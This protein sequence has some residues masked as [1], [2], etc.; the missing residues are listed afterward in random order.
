MG[1]REA[2]KT[3]WQGFSEVPSIET[4]MLNKNAE[5]FDENDRKD[6][7]TS[8]PDLTGLRVVEIG[9]GIG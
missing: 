7:W 8:L 9:S 3:F 6:I 2:L 5:A 4:M 1:D